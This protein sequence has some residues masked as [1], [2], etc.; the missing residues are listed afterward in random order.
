MYGVQVHSMP[1]KF[2]GLMISYFGSRL[3]Q[4]NRKRS[5]RNG[6]FPVY[7]IVPGEFILSSAIVR[8][9]VYCRLK[10]N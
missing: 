2:A 10:D 9:I 8:I 3:I 1:I 5:G 7:S 6:K 4:V